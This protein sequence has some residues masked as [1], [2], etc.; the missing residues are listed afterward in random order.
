MSW[1]MREV[2]NRDCEGPVGGITLLER[3]AF[4]QHKVIPMHKPG[5]PSPD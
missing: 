4:E 2:K 1:A 5:F 3:Q